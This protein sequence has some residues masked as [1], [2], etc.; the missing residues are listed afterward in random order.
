MAGFLTL[1][2]RID[3]AGIEKEF[4]RGVKEAV[5]VNT[6]Q[7]AQAVKS[8]IVR[9]DNIDTGTYL[10]G[11]NHK[12]EVEGKGTSVTGIVESDVSGNPHGHRGYAVFLE[13]GT[14]RHMA[15]PNFTDALEQYSTQ[16]VE[17]LNRIRV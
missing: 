14:A 13:Q 4:V 1:T 11:V 15:F 6:S 7:M 10:E 17:K 2:K 9:R 12:T 8:N 3:F 16:M 5:E